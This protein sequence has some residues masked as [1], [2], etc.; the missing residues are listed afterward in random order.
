MLKPLERLKVGNECDE[1]WEQS[2]VIQFDSSRWVC[3][4]AAVV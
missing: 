2:R 3:A 4:G 1:S